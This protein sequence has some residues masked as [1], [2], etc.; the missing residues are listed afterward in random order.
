VILMTKIGRVGRLLVAAAVA[1]AVLPAGVAVAQTQVERFDRQRDQ[2]Q[3]E[4]MLRELR[5]VPAGQRALFDY[6]G[7][8]T[9]SYL[10]LQDQLADTHVLR[11][12]DLVG[13][14]RL[15]LD[16]AHEFYARG[17][18]TWRDFAPGDSFDGSGDDY[19]GVLERATYRFDLQRYQA[20]RGQSIDY[21]VSV[22][23]GRQLVYWGNGLVI[24]QVLDGAV[25]TL[26]KGIVNLQAVAGVTPVRTVDF[27]SSRPAFDDHTHRAFY[28]ALL[29]LDLGAHRPFVYALLQKDRN[30]TET[31]ET[32]PIRT[33]FDY[34]SLYLGAG[35][36]GAIGDRLLYGAEVVY[37][38]GR[39]LSNSFDVVGGFPAPIEQTQELTKAFG[40]DVR[41][42]YF[43]TDAGR[44]R[45]GAE[46][47]LATGDDDR[48]HTSNTFGGNA[49]GSD[50]EAFNAFGLVNNGLAFAPA[51]SNLVVVRVGASTSPFASPAWLNRL[52]VGT[53]V[54]WFNKMDRNAP[55]DESTAVGRYLGWE[56]DFFVNWQI[57]SDVTLAM[58]YG[59]FFPNEDVF[60]SSD[61]RQ[62]FF[63]ALTFAF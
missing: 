41:L 56:P 11:Q 37:E 5:D 4:A 62:F 17:R 2:L 14:G 29:T 40:A 50:D 7:Y 8:V 45:V 10:T 34:D 54:F 28:G 33:R 18:A 38:G 6:G 61:S 13:Y 1:L 52:Q 12:L 63:A 15:S 55:I 53:D 3:R 30:H 24:S 47:I 27:D 59:V 42:D 19:E 51:V 48:R 35:G 22:Q 46:V 25:I 58:R 23:V 21:N 49:S 36:N 31:R 60:P 39:G 44:T 20:T 16:G 9:L 57:R 43:F 32:G 26:E